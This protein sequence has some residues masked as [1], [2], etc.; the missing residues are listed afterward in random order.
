MESK[1]KKRFFTSHSKSSA[2]VVSL[3]LH[4]VLLVVALSFVAVT[5]VSDFLGL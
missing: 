5:V 2:M 1:R 3:A 4:A